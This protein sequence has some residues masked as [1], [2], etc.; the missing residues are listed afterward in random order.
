[1]VGHQP[2][3]CLVHVGKGKVLLYSLP[4]VGPGADSGEP[5]GDYFFSHPRW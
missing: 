3:P 1:M 5:A 2:L 4:S